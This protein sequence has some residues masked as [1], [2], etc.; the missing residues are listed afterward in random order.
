MILLSIK[1]IGIFRE[2]MPTNVCMPLQYLTSFH[3][4]KMGGGEI[5]HLPQ[6]VIVVRVLHDF[7]LLNY[8]SEMNKISQ[9]FKESICQQYVVDCY[10]SFEQYRLCGKPK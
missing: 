9:F 2:L 3:A 10:A 4:T 5:F 7:M 1:Q 8:N 6:E